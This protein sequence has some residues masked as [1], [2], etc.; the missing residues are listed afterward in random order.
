MAQ[1]W[2]FMTALGSQQAQFQKQYSLPIMSES[3]ES[4]IRAFAGTR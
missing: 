3:H 4:G 2:D 1:F